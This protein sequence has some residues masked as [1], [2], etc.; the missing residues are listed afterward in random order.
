MPSRCS[1]IFAPEVEGRRAAIS[2]CAISNKLQ[3]VIRLHLYI[4]RCGILHNAASNGLRCGKALHCTMCGWMNSNLWSRRPRQPLC[5]KFVA[6][7]SCCHFK[8]QSR[9]F[10]ASTS[11]PA[12]KSAHGGS[13]SAVPATKSAPR[14]HTEVHKAL[15]SAA[16]T[17]KSA[18]GGSQSAAPATKSAHGGSQSAVPAT[19]SAHGEVHKVLRLP[20][21]LHFKEQL[22]T[23]E[24]SNHNGGTSPTMI[25]P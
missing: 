3:V 6:K 2:E 10:S 15:C 7:S 17:T 18:H 1:Q 8:I 21:N 22:K 19:K 4:W 24:N 25:R 12:T 5:G 11:V 20:R 16:P 14:G 23:I 13:Q 9:Q